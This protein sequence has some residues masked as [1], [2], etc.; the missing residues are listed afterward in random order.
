MARVCCNVH[1]YHVSD[2]PKLP[3]HPLSTTCFAVEIISLYLWSE[4]T[5]SPTSPLCN[6]PPYSSIN[7]TSP[8]SA[9]WPCY[10][11]REERLV[12]CEKLSLPLSR[13]CLR[14]GRAGLSPLS[15]PTS[16]SWRSPSPACPPFLQALHCM[17]SGTGRPTR[18]S[19]VDTSTITEPPGSARGNRPVHG[20]LV[21]VVVGETRMAWERWR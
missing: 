8:V 7:G 3:M 20:M 2:L 6:A 12:A 19:P 5:F 18:T 11:V 1:P 17:S 13:R 14:R 16:R 4:T 15:T 21:P 9:C 10:S